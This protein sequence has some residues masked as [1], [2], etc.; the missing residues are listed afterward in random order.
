MKADNYNAISIVCAAARTRR[1]NE[2]I[3]ELGKLYDE[4]K[5]ELL[6]A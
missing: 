1:D 6:N 4:L 3:V 2:T 5:D